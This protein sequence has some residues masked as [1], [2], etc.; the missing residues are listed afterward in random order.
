MQNELADLG[1]N[2]FIIGINEVGFENANVQ[3]TEGR[4]IPWLQ[5]QEE[6]LLWNNWNV[7]YRDVYIY[8]ETLLLREV[9]NLSQFDLTDPENYASFINTLTTL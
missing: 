3:I 4:D 8:D 9:V 2:T 6:I 5:D 7:K 1:Y